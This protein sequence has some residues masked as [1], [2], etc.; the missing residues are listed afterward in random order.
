MVDENKKTAEIPLLKWV[1]Q[2]ANEMF[3]IIHSKTDHKTAEGLQ[4]RF[5]RGMENYL[6]SLAGDIVH[7]DSIIFKNRQPVSTINPRGVYLQEIEEPHSLISLDCGTVEE[8]DFRLFLARDPRP[9]PDKPNTLDGFDIFKVSPRIAILGDEGMGKSS[10]L[11]YLANCALSSRQD[12][13][14]GGDRLPFMISLPLVLRHHSKI[15]LY[16]FDLLAGFGIPENE[17]KVF[18]NRLLEQGKILFLIDD[19]GRCD[20]DKRVDLMEQINQLTDLYP[21]NLF[22]VALRDNVHRRELYRFREVRMYRPGSSE[23]LGIALKRLENP[24]KTM[25]HISRHQKYPRIFD[26]ARTPFFLGIICRLAE[27]GEPLT[28]SSRKLL[29]AW[30]KLVFKTVLAEHT[31]W[32]HSFFLRISQDTFLDWLSYLAMNAYRKKLWMIPRSELVKSSEEF[33]RNMDIGSVDFALVMDDLA[34]VFG[35]MLWRGEGYY[36]FSHA[37]LFR[38]LAAQYLVHNYHGFKFSGYQSRAAR[39]ILFYSFE[40]MIDADH[41]FRDI[42]FRT[43]S[44]VF[45]SNWF[46]AV[47]CLSPE[48]FVR[49]EIRHKI[50]AFIKKIRS[51]SHIPFF[52]LQI[53]QLLKNSRSY[54]L[55]F[56]MT[57][58]LKSPEPFDRFK[59]LGFIQE[60]G[61]Q[62]LEKVVSQVLTSDKDPAVRVRAADTLGSFRNPASVKVLE[63]VAGSDKESCVRRSC[64]RAVGTIRHPDSFATVLE[65]FQKQGDFDVWAEAA[66]ALVKFRNKATVEI[67]LNALRKNKDPKHIEVLVEV[68]GELNAKSVMAILLKMLE[69]KLGDSLKERLFQSLCRLSVHIDPKFLLKALKGE[70]SRAMQEFAAFACGRLFIREATPILTHLLQDENP[71]LRRYSAFSLGLLGEDQALHAL[72]EI[73]DPRHDEEARLHAA[74]GLVLLRNRG[75]VEPFIMYLKEDKN[76][77]IRRICARGLGVLG[78]DVGI[79]PLVA[80]LANDSEVVVRAEAA[81]ALAHFSDKK[82]LKPLIDAYKAKDDPLLQNACL[83]ALFIQAQRFNLTIDENYNIVEAD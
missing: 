31:D 63:Q 56:E 15:I 38:S 9:L 36:T 44:D 77:I 80:A 72:L 51:D 58:K 82:V 17:V 34:N 37:L 6:R 22:A 12:K 59:A 30:L 62:V 20:V 67:V 55:L 40:G 79:E 24:Q 4:T 23:M 2:E 1:K 14:L 65:I 71:A 28:D 11:L 73:F 83:E 49:R 57:E 7:A 70:D 53:S 46:F 43:K 45:K 39:D 8:K 68:A 74:C 41:V 5:F 61:N 29:V 48:T 69:G 64:V 33:F 13:M 10:W 75:A 50:N 47:G 3:T 27:A 35:V 76:H 81:Q 25:K 18:F 21:N 52:Q 19:L 26:M 16:I 54:T 42:L 60:I 32:K 78:S 66:R